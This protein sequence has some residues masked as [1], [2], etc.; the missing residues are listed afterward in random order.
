MKKLKKYLYLIVNKVF[1]LDISPLDYSIGWGLRDSDSHLFIWGNRTSELFKDRKNINITGSIQ[2]EKL[3]N[4]YGIQKGSLKII[5]DIAFK[6]KRTILLSAQCFLDD[7]LK[8]KTLKTYHQLIKNTSLFNI[9]IKIHPRDEISFFDE[10]KVYDNVWIFKNEYSFDTLL[11]ISDINISHYSA[12][13]MASIVYG[14]P[15]ILLHSN[16]LSEDTCDFWFSSKVFY[17]SNKKQL[18]DSYFDKILNRCNTESYAEQRNNFLFD[19][20]SS[21]IG[22]SKKFLKEKLDSLLYS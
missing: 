19:M 11:K 17:K 10:F 16:V 20:F 14:I 2:M 15:V 22:N 4:G 1:K 6:Q 18:N 8:H 7:S 3:Y 9:I 21:N 5:P 12:T 13:S